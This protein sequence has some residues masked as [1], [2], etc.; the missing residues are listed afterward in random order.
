MREES[1]LAW[2]QE[3]GR[4]R[5]EGEEKECQ[6]RGRGQGEEK[7]YG[8]EMG[9]RDRVRGTKG[10]ER[11]KKEDTGKRALGLRLDARDLGKGGWRG[12]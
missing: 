12:E 6:G 11:K 8:E 1:A 9:D 7:R 2:D 10:R 5:G 4:E 3:I